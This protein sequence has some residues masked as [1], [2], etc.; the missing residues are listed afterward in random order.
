MISIKIGS[1][2]SIDAE[3]VNSCLFYDKLTLEFSFPD[4]SVIKSSL[5]PNRV[6]FTKNKKLINEKITLFEK[7]FNQKIKIINPK[8]ILFIEYFLYYFCLILKNIFVKFF[9]PNQWV[10]AYR[11]IGNKDWKIIEFKKNELMA[12]PFIYYCDN[13]YYLFYEGLNYDVDRGYI[14]AGELD[15]EKNKIINIKKIINESYHLSFPYIFEIN[16]ELYMVP[17]SS[18]NHTVD[19]YKCNE[20][21]YK[22]DKVKTLI[23]NIEAVDT[24]LIKNENMWYLLTSEKVYGASYGDELTIFISEDPLKKPFRRISDMPAVHDIAL[25][26]NA[27]SIYVSKA[28]NLYRVSQD[29]SRRYGFKVN[30]MKITQLS[31]K[32]KYR[33]EL[34]SK[35][36]L[37]KNAI[38]MHTYNFAHEIEITDLKIINKDIASLLR[39][40][41]RIFKKIWASIRSRIIS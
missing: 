14:C 26:R 28:G 15:T 10:I 35:F 9:M 16:S 11:K 34:I 31:E 24:V 13:K 25:A 1:G 33:E 2:K 30:I 39:N 37:P 21:P 12:D 22:W 8:R 4:G 36:D 27:G 5:L 17:E 20:F 29:C 32:Y 38:A 6:S 19:L 40:A 23:G 3:V 41:R 18:N 7:R